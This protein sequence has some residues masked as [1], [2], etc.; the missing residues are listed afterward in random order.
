MSAPM[1]ADS[2]EHFFHPDFAVAGL[3]LL[4]ESYTFQNFPDWTRPGTCKCSTG[5]SQSM[6]L[7]GISCEL[8]EANCYLRPGMLKMTWLPHHCRYS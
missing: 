8:T 3:E 4:K 6:L 2:V 5:Y 7:I 1:I